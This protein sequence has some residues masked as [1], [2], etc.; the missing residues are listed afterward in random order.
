[1]AIVISIASQKGGVGDE[2]KR[3][4]AVPQ[5]KRD[6]AP[7]SFVVVDAVIQLAHW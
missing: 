4:V 3:S 7:R 2:A 1:M 6:I 5:K